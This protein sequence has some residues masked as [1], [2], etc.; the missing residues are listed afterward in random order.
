MADI[1]SGGFASSVRFDC[2][3]GQ[4]IH[5]G[6]LKC[7]DQAADPESPSAQV[8]QGIDHPLAGTMIGDLAAPVRLVQGYA[9]LRELPV[10]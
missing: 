7:A 6:L 10:S 2:I 8:Q 3:V 5:D 4:H 1:D 9:H